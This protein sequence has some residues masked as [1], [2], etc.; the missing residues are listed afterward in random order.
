MAICGFDRSRFEEVLRKTL[1]PTTPIRSAEFLRGRDQILEVIRRALVQPGRHVF[2]HGDRGVG[3]TSLAQTAAFEHQSAGAHPIIV[4]CDNASTFYR[5]A[6]NVAQAL[7]NATSSPGKA[8]TSKKIAVGWPGFISLEIQRTIEQGAVPEFKL[9]NEA[10]GSIGFLASKHSEYP[11]IVI[12]EFERI[13]DAGE[14]MLFADFVEQ[15][16]DQSVPI[17]LIFCGIGSSLG[18]LLDSHHSCYRYLSSIHLARIMHHATCFCTSGERTRADVPKGSSVSS[19][20]AA[21]A[22]G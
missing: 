14:R 19:F 20:M 12:D 4:G 15:V 2:V 17:K 5:I 7:L 10:V 9:I 21:V 13:R 11:V 8:N 22:E 3:K 16:G 1:S 18:E 6:L